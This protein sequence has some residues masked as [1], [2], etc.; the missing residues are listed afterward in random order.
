MLGWLPEADLLPAPERSCA[1]A[2]SAGV[3][4]LIGYKGQVRSR[5]SVFDE[6]SIFEIN[7]ERKKN[8]HFYCEMVAAPPRT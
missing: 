8:G 7:K 3:P 1:G 6:N 2:P 5:F 4:Q